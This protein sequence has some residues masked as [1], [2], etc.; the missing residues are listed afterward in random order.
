M[1]LDKAIESGKEHRKYYR[2]SKAFDRTCRNHGNCRHCRENRLYRTRKEEI[3]CHSKL[4]C[5]N[6]YPKYTLAF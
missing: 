5:R 2:G 6:I 3:K 4:D 1:P